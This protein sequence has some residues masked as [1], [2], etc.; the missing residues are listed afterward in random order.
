MH[1]YVS[2]SLVLLLLGCGGGNTNRTARPEAPVVRIASGPVASACAQS[3]RRAANRQLCGCIQAVADDSL[4][5]G[6]QRRAAAFFRDPHQ[7]Q[8]V[9]Q[10]DGRR[11]EAFWDRYTAFADRAERICRGL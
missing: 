2:L 3:G 6:D 5:A 11:D 1:R 4:S 9:R 10:S 8:E 7:A